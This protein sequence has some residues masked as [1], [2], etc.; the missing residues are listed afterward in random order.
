[1]GVAVKRRAGFPQGQVEKYFEQY[2]EPVVMAGLGK[3][4]TGILRVWIGCGIGTSFD[5]KWSFPLRYFVS[6]V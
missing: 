2:F 3:M 5:C 1:M 6:R 4:L